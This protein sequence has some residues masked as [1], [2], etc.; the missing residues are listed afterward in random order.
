MK[1][2]TER[3]HFAKFN[4]CVIFYQMAEFFKDAS[5]EIERV[6]LWETLRETFRAHA[7]VCGIQLPP[8]SPA[9]IICPSADT[10]DLQI[11]LVLA[12]EPLEEDDTIQLWAETSGSNLITKVSILYFDNTGRE[13]FNYDLT[14]DS[15]M[16]HSPDPTALDQEDLS[17]LRVD[18]SEACW[19]AEISK[20]CANSLLYFS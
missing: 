7:Q 8:M 19:S 12:D 2:R 15:L 20:K 16:Q 17:D 1:Q 5:V 18:I 14:P 6:F 4:I 11:M 9:E 3:R 10:V 13:R